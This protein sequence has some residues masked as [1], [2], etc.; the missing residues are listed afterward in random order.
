MEKATTRKRYAVIIGAGPAGLT[1][2]WECLERSDIIPIV[3]EASDHVGGISATIDYKG[4]KLDIGGHRFF[5]KSSKILEWWFHFLPLQKGHNAEAIFYRNVNTHLPLLEAR[6]DP[7]RCDD[8]MLV[9]KR[10]SHILF[11]GSLF[12][13]PIQPSWSM[14]RTLG[15]RRSLRCALS[16]ARSAFLPIVPEKNLEDFFINRFGRELYESF[17]RSY[18]EKVW[19]V[20]CAALNAEW[21]KQRIK[22]LSLW[23]FLGKRKNHTS[24]IEQFLYPKYGPG[25]LWQCVAREVEKRGGI[26]RFNEK[27]DKIDCSP[28]GAIYSISTIHAITHERRSYDAAYA[29]SS[30]PIKELVAVLQCSVP[31]HV[32]E[33]ATGLAYRDFITVGIL[34]RRIAFEARGEELRDTWIYIH[35]PQIKAGRVQFFHNWSPYATANPEHRWIGVEYFCSADD[36]FWNTTDEEIKEHAVGEMEV[37]G[38]IKGCDVLDAV[39]VRMPK[40]YPAY[41][42]SYKRFSELRS[43]LDAIPNLFLIGRNGMHKYNNQDHSMLTAVA[44]VDAIAAGSTDKSKIWNIN[45]DDSYHEEA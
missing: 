34:L 7:E 31:P 5:S 10:I 33:V 27:I 26:I 40:A 28:N 43:W 1:A 45:I 23:S 4:N 42:G 36:A 44:A 9:R 13:Y 21:G 25:H 20:P 41:T 39:V 16:Y 15:L 35:E 38:L 6:A 22:R 2:A 14:I 19:G 29:I 8:V 37:I 12:D 3:L 30:M 17:F 18:T 24:L 11:S 32:K